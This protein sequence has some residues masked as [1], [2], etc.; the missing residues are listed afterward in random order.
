MGRNKGHLAIFLQTGK[1]SE[2]I[3]LDKSKVKNNLVTATADNYGRKVS[4]ETLT[5]YN[6]SNG[7]MEELIKVTI[8]Q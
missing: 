3:I 2:C 4:V 5:A 8:K 7:N 1:P 6:K